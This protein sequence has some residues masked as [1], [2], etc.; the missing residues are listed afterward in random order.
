M[1]YQGTI[2]EFIGDAI[3]AIFGA[4]VKRPD[5]ARRA[6]ACAL[7]MQLAMDRVNRWNRQRGYPDIAMGIGINT[8]EVVVGNIGSE[9]RAKYGVVGRHVNLTSRIESCT[10]GGQILASDSTVDACGS[11]VEIA[12]HIVIN[13]KGIDG[14]VTVHEVVAIGGEF[15]VSLSRR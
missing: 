6:V 1:R 10:V 4:P 14:A 11:I 5:D 7:E 8:G 13:P 2:D 12:D 9:H 15:E 3:L